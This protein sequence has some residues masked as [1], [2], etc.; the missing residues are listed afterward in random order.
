MHNKLAVTMN[1]NNIHTKFWFDPEL[2]EPVRGQQHTY[3][4]WD[5]PH[6]LIIFTKAFRQIYFQGGASV[7]QSLFQ[8]DLKM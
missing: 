6:L 8:P 2:T 3:H 4:S 7:L 5:E 1:L